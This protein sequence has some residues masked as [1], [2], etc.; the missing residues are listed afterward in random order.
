MDTTVKHTKMMFTLD[1]IQVFV[2]AITMMVAIILALFL[3]KGILTYAFIAVAVIGFIYLNIAI[4][5]A[6]KDVEEL[7]TLLK[8]RRTKMF[9]P[10]DYMY[11]M[12][13]D[14]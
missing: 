8:V 12:K 10:L 7:P 1:I 2:S 4:S 9:L 5:M 11:K 13:K 6:L 14:N 3:E